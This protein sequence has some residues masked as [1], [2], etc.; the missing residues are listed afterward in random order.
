MVETPPTLSPDK[1]EHH[2]IAHDEVC[3]HVNDL[4][5]TEWVACGEQPLRQKG[6]GRIVH[7]SDFIIERTGRLSLTSANLVIAFSLFSC[8]FFLRCLSSLSTLTTFFS[9]QCNR[10]FKKPVPR[11]IV[12][13]HLCRVTKG[14]PPR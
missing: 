11:F 5:R 9:N 6:R 1:K 12:L 13:Y 3:F 7:V 8:L 2:L 10:D 14:S 4:S